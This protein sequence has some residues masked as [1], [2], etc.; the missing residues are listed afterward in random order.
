MLFRFA[1][2]I[3][4]DIIIQG[5][6]E[7]KRIEERNSEDFSARE[8]KE[9]RKLIHDAITNNSIMVVEEFLKDNN[10]ILR[11]N[12]NEHEHDNEHKNSDDNLKKQVVGFIWFTITKK[13]FVG[14]NNCDLNNSYIYISYVWINKKCRGQGLAKEL[15]NQVFAYGKENNISKIWLDIHLINTYSETFHKQLGFEPQVVIYSKSI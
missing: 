3:D 4:N 6:L 1:T 12:N 14:I 5:L 8:E 10:D 2:E 7:I 9:Q 11:E 13:C 15:Y